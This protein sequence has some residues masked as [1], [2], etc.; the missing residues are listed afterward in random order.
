MSQVMK[1]IT[2]ID[3]GRPYHPQTQGIVERFN[4]SVKH[5]VRMDQFASFTAISRSLI[6][7]FVFCRLLRR[8]MRS[9]VKPKRTESRRVH[10]LT[11]LMMSSRITTTRGTKSLVKLRSMHWGVSRAQEFWA[12][13]ASRLSIEQCDKG[14]FKRRSTIGMHGIRNTVHQQNSKLDS[15]MFSRIHK[16]E[17]FCADTDDPHT[18]LFFAVCLLNRGKIGYETKGKVGLV[19]SAVVLYS[20]W[21]VNIDLCGW[22]MDWKV[23]TQDKKVYPCTLHGLSDAFTFATRSWYGM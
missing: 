16:R 14:L 4:R 20:V 19:P 8:W 15:C 18:F 13:A 2:K 1:G 10:G 3:H 9:T 12:R 5:W 7:S 22:V 23:N 11:C 6:H 17:C 21:M